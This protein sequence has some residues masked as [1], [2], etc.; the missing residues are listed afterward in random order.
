MHRSQRGRGIWGAGIAVGF[1]GRCLRRRLRPRGLERRVGRLPAAAAGESSSSSAFPRASCSSGREVGGGGAGGLGGSESAGRGRRGAGGTPAGRRRGRPR[2]GRRCA[3]RRHRPLAPR[4][5]CT[6]EYGTATGF[7]L[8]VET[9]TY[10]DFNLNNGPHRDSCGATCSQLRRRLHPRVGQPRRLRPLHRRRLR[11]RRRAF[12]HDALPLH[13]LLSP[14][15]TPSHQRVDDREIVVEVHR[16]VALVP[17]RAS[18]RRSETSR[19]RRG[20][21]PRTS[22]LALLN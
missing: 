21:S 6:D 3:A 12:R 8:C 15:S 18:C 10:C 20:S 14:Q 7:V 1:V 5:S 2:A 16:V 19:S 17:G 11:L 13:P 4:Q 22:N 9:P